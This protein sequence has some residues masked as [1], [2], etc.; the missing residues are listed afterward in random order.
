VLVNHSQLAQYVSERTEVPTSTVTLVTNALL[1][2]VGTALAAGDS[3][4][5]RRFGKFEP[6]TRK[7][8]VRKNPATGEE[9]PVPEHTTVAFVPSPVLRG[10]VNDGHADFRDEEG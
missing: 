2:A 7:A 1:E 8:M 3:V 9:I 6:R 10:R 5:L 4:N